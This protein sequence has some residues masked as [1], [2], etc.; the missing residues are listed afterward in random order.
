MMEATAIDRAAAALAEGLR[1]VLVAVRSAAGGGSGTAWTADGLVVTNH[2][3]VPGGRA[4]VQL[5]DGRRLGASVRRRDPALDLALLDVGQPLEAVATPGS[6]ADLRVGEL[7]FAAGNPWGEPGVV[8]R[9]IL[10]ARGPSS[11]EGSVPLA[12]ALRADVR[13]APGNSGGPLADA[14]GRVVGINAMIA[15]GMAIAVPVEAVQELVAGP[16]LPARIGISGRAVPLPPAIAAG[17]RASDGLGVLVTEVE[18][19][20]PALRAGLLPGDVLVGFA[21][22]PGGAAALTRGLRRLRDGERREL[23]LLRGFELRTLAVEAAA[24]S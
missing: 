21:G 13:L 9:G 19:D 5:P 1:A 4:E 8:T 7:V 11:V 3:V 18:A 15:G 16:P 22:E 10:S 17:A 23:R 2:H 24:R 12:E 20:S 6:S 14:R